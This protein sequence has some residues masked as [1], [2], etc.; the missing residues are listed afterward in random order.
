MGSEG[1][2]GSRGIIVMESAYYTVTTLTRG[3]I[4][5]IYYTRKIFL[6][7]VYYV[8]PQNSNNPIMILPL[9]LSLYTVHSFTVYIQCTVYNVNSCKQ[10]YIV[11]HIST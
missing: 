4:N 1:S 7:L 11:V 3:R 10:L 8:T 6:R 9:S 5:G 2:E